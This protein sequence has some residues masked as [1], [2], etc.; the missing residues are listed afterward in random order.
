[1]VQMR[2]YSLH[3]RQF[4]AVFVAFFI[5]LLITILIGIAGPTVIRSKS[6]TKGLV[7]PYEI[8]SGFLEKFHQRLWLTVQVN[9]NTKDEYKQSLNVQVDIT[10]G[11]GSKSLSNSYNRTRTIHCQQQ[12]SNFKNETTYCA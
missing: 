3:K 7:G 12:V 9:V 11:K 4:V 8:P 6:F 5:L 2:L 10:D 1:S